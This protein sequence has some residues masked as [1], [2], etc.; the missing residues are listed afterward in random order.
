MDTIK[1]SFI[2]YNDIIDSTDELSDQEAGKL[3]KMILAKVNGKPYECN[4][5]LIKL[6]LNP[7]EKSID[8]NWQKYENKLKEKSYAGQ[9]GNLKRWHKDL[10]DEFRKGKID[11]NEAF[12]IVD[13]RKKSQSDKSVTEIADSDPDNAHDPESIPIPDSENVVDDEDGKKLMDLY[14]VGNKFLKDK[15]VVNAFIESHNLK[16]RKHLIEKMKSFHLQLKKDKKT[17]KTL[18]DYSKH[19]DSWL[20][21]QEGKTSSQYNKVVGGASAADV[22]RQYGIKR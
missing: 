7:I 9:I 18:E 1:N 14:T 21:K 10:Y 17:Q 3:F 20:N 11:L 19:L 22:D 2:L 16:N 4:E 8:R 6:V 5:K 12:K 13:S 15:E